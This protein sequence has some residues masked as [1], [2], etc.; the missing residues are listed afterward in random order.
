MRIISKVGHGLSNAP[1]GIFQKQESNMS[2]NDTW[3]RER[4]IV[5]RQ[6][7]IDCG[8]YDPEKL[9]QICAVVAAHDGASDAD[10]AKA[11]FAAFPNATLGVILAACHLSGSLR[12]MRPDLQT[13]KLGRKARRGR[14]LTPHQGLWTL[15]YSLTLGCLDYL[16]N[17]E[18][19][20]A[21]GWVRQRAKPSRMILDEIVAAPSLTEAHDHGT[22]IAFISMGMPA[23]CS[24]R[25]R[26]PP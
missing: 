21:H 25:R 16:R 19:F 5:R 13:R 26:K 17:S 8:I 14:T 24:F 15:R 4:G 9:D 1:G 10:L 3:R 18:G 2:L 23:C 12:R 11:V 6:I 7:V 22:S 20:N